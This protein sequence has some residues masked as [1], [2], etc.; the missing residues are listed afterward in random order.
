MWHAPRLLSLTM[1]ERFTGG[2][3]MKR[4]FLAPTLLSSLFSAH[5]S[6]RDMVKSY[7]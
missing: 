2:T 7:Y 5:S 1:G 4:K 3:F 6:E